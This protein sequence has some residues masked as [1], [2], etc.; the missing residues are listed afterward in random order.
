M[1][2]AVSLLTLS[3]FASRASAI[4]SSSATLDSD[5]ERRALSLPFFPLTVDS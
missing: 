2:Y 5:A 4:A 1:D 3:S